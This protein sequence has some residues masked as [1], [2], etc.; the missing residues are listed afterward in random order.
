MATRPI[1]SYENPP[2]VEAVWSVQFAELAWMTAPHTGFFWERIKGD[3]PICQEVAPLNRMYEPESLPSPVQ[4]VMQ[5]RSRPPACRQMFISQSKQDLI[6]IQPDRF[7]VNWRQVTNE[8]YPRYAYLESAFRKN[9]GQFSEF[10]KEFGDDVP[11]QTDYCEMT[12]VNHVYQ[13]EGWDEI[14]DI[15][16][17]LSGMGWC[18]EAKFLPSPSTL[19]YSMSFDL[20]DPKGRLHVKC[21]HARTQEEPDRQ[22]LRLE[23]TA[24]GTPGDTDVDG[25]VQWFSVAREWIVRGFADLTSLGI[26]ETQWHRKQ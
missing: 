26:Q 17:V 21:G 19:A 18:T 22:L 12:Y 6:Q 1:P 10:V 3:Y 24:R 9:W 4:I 23:L 14:A 5:G 16:N 13:G 25:L 8:E 20:L 11:T 7:C 15:G 2:I